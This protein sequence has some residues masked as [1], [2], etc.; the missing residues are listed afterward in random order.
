MDDEREVRDVVAEILASQG[1]EVVQ[2]AGG[3][4]GLEY[5]DRGSPV[6][7]ILTDLGMPG[8]TGWEVARAAKARRPSLSVGLLTGWG[9]QP[10]AK[11]EDR[12]AADFVI[13]KPV[14]V[15]GLKAAIANLRRS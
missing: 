13:A 14:T 15:A 4:E 6:D 3:V 11:P 8:M 5:L 10:I 2:A 7:L 9:E 12:A 1:H